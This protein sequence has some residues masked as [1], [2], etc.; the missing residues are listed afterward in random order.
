[1]WLVAVVAPAQMRPTLIGVHTPGRNAC[2]DRSPNV[3]RGPLLGGKVC[4]GRGFRLLA[5]LRWGDQPSSA[6]IIPGYPNL[7]RG[8][9]LGHRWE[10]P[11]GNYPGNSGNYHYPFFLVIFMVILH[12]F[13]WKNYHE[14]QSDCYPFFLIM[15]NYPIF[16]INYHIIIFQ[17][18]YQNLFLLLEYPKN[19]L[20]FFYQRV[21]E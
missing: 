20:V 4:G 12:D 21:L 8:H 1:M 15:V 10:L 18:Y 19:A 6:S 2:P 13:I 17:M 7:P 11:V 3:S 5:S 16:L 9:P 14:N